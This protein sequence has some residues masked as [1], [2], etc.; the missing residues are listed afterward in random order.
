MSHLLQLVIELALLTLLL[1]YK[2]GAN[3]SFN[4]WFLLNTE[5]IQPCEKIVFKVRSVYGKGICL[6]N[7]LLR[8][9]S[10][11]LCFNLSLKFLLT[12]LFGLVDFCLACCM[13]NAETWVKCLLTMVYSL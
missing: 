2:D 13:D 8:S 7:K 5:L 6:F 9:G 1:G 10:L 12:W 3:N 4:D 11:G